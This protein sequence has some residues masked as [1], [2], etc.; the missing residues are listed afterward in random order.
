MYS[1]FLLIQNAIYFWN[2]WLTNKKNRMRNL[3]TSGI[4]TCS[5]EIVK[6]YISSLMNCYLFCVLESPFFFFLFLKILS[7]NEKVSTPS[8]REKNPNN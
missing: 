7:K 6:L 1:V 4:F 8:F 5:C 2:K 3:W